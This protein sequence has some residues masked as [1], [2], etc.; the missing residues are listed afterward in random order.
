MRRG[1]WRVALSRMGKRLFFGVRARVFTELRG[2][3]GES[4]RRGQEKGGWKAS[5]PGFWVFLRGWVGRYPVLGLAER[6]CFGKQTPKKGLFF[7][8]I[9]GFG[10]CFWGQSNRLI[11]E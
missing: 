7:H 10:D 9:A 2:S 11:V 5:H 4:G 3:I 8:S 6:D 1:D